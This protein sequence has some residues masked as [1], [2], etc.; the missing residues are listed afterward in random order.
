MQPQ[1]AGIS[2]EGLPGGMGGRVLATWCCNGSRSRGVTP[3]PYLSGIQVACNGM[4]LL[5]IG[6]GS[7]QECKSQPTPSGGWC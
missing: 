7:Y 6:S 5:A 2:F 1:S 3:I 4:K